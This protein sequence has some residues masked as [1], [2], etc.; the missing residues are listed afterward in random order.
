[1]ENDFFFILSEL[2]YVHQFRFLSVFGSHD[3]TVWSSY[4]FLDQPFD[5][6]IIISL[7]FII[8]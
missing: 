1:M 2:P 7:E 6:T 8:G 3:V 5:F 4:H